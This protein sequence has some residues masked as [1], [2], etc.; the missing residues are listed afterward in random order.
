MEDLRQTGFELDFRAI[1]VDLSLS[2]LKYQCDLS[3]LPLLVVS[4]KLKLVITYLPNR[5]ELII[6]EAL[7]LFFDMK[8]HLQ[9]WQF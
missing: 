2:K 5:I 6:P 7:C 9:K 3:G 1:V 4:L 8:H